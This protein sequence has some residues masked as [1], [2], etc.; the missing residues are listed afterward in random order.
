[1]ENPGSRSLERPHAARRH[2][3]SILYVVAIENGCVIRDP[4]AASS[5]CGI[6]FAL[7]PSPRI[8]ITFDDPRR[9]SGFA[10]VSESARYSTM[11]P[12]PHDGPAEEGLSSFDSLRRSRIRRGST[13]SG[14]MLSSFNHRCRN[15]LNGIKM[16]LYLFK[17]EVGRTDAGTPGTSWSGRISSSRC[18]SIGS[19]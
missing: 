9:S 1:M 10:E 16:S 6:W 4:R 11:S 17:R 5:R 18:C 8:R 3:D 13:T 19:R 14:E 7:G 15:S 12:Q 2:S